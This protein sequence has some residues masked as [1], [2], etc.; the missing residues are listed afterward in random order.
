ML[1]YAAAGIWRDRAIFCLPGPSKAVELGWR[2][3]IEPEIDHLAW[4]LVR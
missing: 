3:L 2:A 1:S 4:E